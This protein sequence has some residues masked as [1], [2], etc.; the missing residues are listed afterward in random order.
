M[1]RSRMAG[2]RSRMAGVRS[3]SSASPVPSRF[4]ASRRGDRRRA[5]L[6]RR[7]LPSHRRH[8][9]QRGRDLGTRL[10]TGQGVALWSR[11]T[12]GSPVRPTRQRTGRVREPH[13]AGRRYRS[14]RIGPTPRKDR[15]LH[16]CWRAH[17]YSNDAA[18]PRCPWCGCAAVACQVH[19]RRQ[20]SLERGPA[21]R[22]H[23]RTVWPGRGGRRS[24][25]LGPCS[26]RRRD[27]GRLSPADRAGHAG[28]C[29]HSGP[30]CRGHAHNRRRCG[31]RAA[32]TAGIAGYTASRHCHRYARALVRR[33]RGR[34]TSGRGSVGASSRRRTEPAVDRGKLQLV[35]SM[36]SFAAGT[37]RP[38]GGPRPARLRC[39]KGRP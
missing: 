7:V 22:R 31:R 14:A 23:G 32:H 15:A 5:A 38:A 6:R 28:C 10:G 3:R 36:A 4:V 20:C 33:E 18:T 11:R 25:R 17:R 39:G 27:W 2:V 30:W 12:A 24:G 21:L 35:G 13:E 26:R 19:E 9:R 29:R 1:W 37:L 34:C 8:R 16:P